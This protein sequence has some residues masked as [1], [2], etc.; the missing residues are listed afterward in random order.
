VAA[1]LLVSQSAY[2]A[3]WSIINIA[4]QPLDA[5]AVVAAADALMSSPAGKGF[6]GRL[7]LQQIVADGDNPATHS[8]VPV[9]R[10]AAERE[11]FVAKLQADPA[12]AKFQEAMAKLSQPV[13]TVLYRTQKRWGNVTDT[14]VVWQTH[15]FDVRDPAAFTAALGAFMASPTGKRFP[16]QIFLSSVVSGGLSPVTHLI[17]VGFASD[18]ARESWQDSI[19][20]G[21]DFET[22]L[23]ASRKAADYLGN[24]MAR[25][26]KT[27][28]APLN[29]VTA[30]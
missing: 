11:A 27:W 18:A 20:G 19:Q 15:A 30:E 28:G 14:D 22:Y 13:S 9:Y 1:I 23:A 12:W 6:P 8:F 4:V 21:T 25:T 26:V 10:S 2:A 5:P 29:E 17:S 16:G 7:F 3:S 24:N